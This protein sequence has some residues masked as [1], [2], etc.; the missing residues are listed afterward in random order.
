MFSAIS[1]AASHAALIDA[2]TRSDPT[3][4]VASHAVNCAAKLCARLALTL[5][6]EDRL[7]RLVRVLERPARPPLNGREISKAAWALGKLWS[8]CS[9]ASA[10]E[11][12]RSALLALAGA[13]A[14]DNGEL[15][16]QAVV[17]TLHALGTVSLWSQGAVRLLQR[18]VAA[19]VS[20]ASCSPQDVA[21]SLW[22]LARLGTSAEAALV[23]AID[24]QI[25]ALLPHFKPLELS[26][27]AWAVAKLQNY[28]AAELERLVRGLHSALL[29]TRDGKGSGGGKGRG[30]KGDGGKGGNGKGGRGKGSGIGGKGAD[31]DGA[32]WRG[33]SAQ[34][35]ANC[36][37]AFARLEPAPPAALL[38][39]LL[40]Q[41]SVQAAYF[42]S[43]GLANVCSACARL[44][45]RSPVPLAL[46]RRD[47]ALDRLG[48]SDVSEIAWALGRLLLAADG[49]PFG[50]SAEPLVDSLVSTSAGSRLGA[51]TPD[52]R[53]LSGA[54]WRRAAA[55]APQLGWQEA[56]QLEFS[57]RMLLHS[58]CA[59]Q[60]A[61]PLTSTAQQS[62]SASAAASTGAAE[63]IPLLSAAVHA[64]LATV[65]RE[66]ATLEL[67]ATRALLS[68]S[69]PPWSSVPAGAPV[70]LMHAGS[71]GRVDA[72]VSAALVAAGFHLCHH[73]RF[74]DAR[75]PSGRATAAT[76]WPRLPTAAK[77]AAAKGAAATSAAA[78]SEG[79]AAEGAAGG[80]VG[81]EGYAAVVL[82]LPPSRAALDFALHAS[83]S[84]LRAGGLLVLFGCREEGVHS[85]HAHVP[86]ALF[87]SVGTA[88]PPGGEGAVLS[89]RRLRG[90]PPEHGGV[91]GSWKV[92]EAHGSSWKLMEGVEG[93]HE[94]CSIALPRV[95]VGSGRAPAAPPLPTTCSR[96]RASCRAAAQPYV[97]AS[98]TAPTGCTYA[99]QPWLTLPGLFAGGL[100]DVMTTAL[101]Q[102][103]PA[104]PPRA[105]VLD[106]CSGS[107]VIGAAL[108][109][110]E[111]SIRL[112]LADADA[113]AVHAARANV[114]T[115]RVHLSDGWGGLPLRPRFHSI[116]S[117]PP[118]HLGL[119]TD[120]RILRTLVAGAARR[121]RAGGSL[122]LVA[123]TYVP[124]GR[125]L[126]MQ[127]RRLQD[128][129]AA[130]DDGRFTVWVATKRPRTAAMAPAE[131]AQ[132]VPNTCSR[133]EADAAA[134]REEVV[135]ATAPLIV[136]TGA[137][138]K[139]R[140]A[141]MDRGAS[142]AQRKRARRMGSS[143]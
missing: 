132:H 83:A 107:G 79:G 18:R 34:G 78:R 42:T 91:E 58:D 26:S 36:L 101:L 37:W 100:V 7:A 17:G 102:T 139:K 4:Q 20:A 6:E 140:S 99:P 113:L 24:A 41:A 35:V 125:L 68:A 59:S 29:C 72:Q 126:A 98:P 77:G 137:S 52:Y 90:P 32:V 49:S 50:T 127:A 134:A 121:L 14:G 38:E 51:A 82:R 11:A 22:A 2:A 64:S 44:E 25:D 108:R 61:L 118:V 84:V 130:Y 94:H 39:A 67:A 43:Q 96:E 8:Y 27:T 133:L 69:P 123:Q 85:T 62:A 28:P 92:V 104:P 88:E 112:H 106:F 55:V 1:A 138:V 10:R 74:A 65:K 109:A 142:K 141:P 54:L 16:A 15:D 70:L 143:T 5:A 13:V 53:S 80:S 66:R 117:N 115:A 19:F 135:R 63:L 71:A 110:A 9:A 128:F 89:A 33:L 73:N 111:P 21:N 103:M 48:A 46:L 93:F 120:F 116:V 40:E 76:P 87:D 105:R 31:S 97:E 95:G 60:L 30:G 131:A 122:W 114:P 119:Q 3:A 56:A 12:I 124:V 57:I 75:L 23:A 81:N 136:P 47:G 86:P 129:R 45:A